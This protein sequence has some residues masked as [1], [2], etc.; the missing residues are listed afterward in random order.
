MTNRKRRGSTGRRT[1][2]RA[3]SGSAAAWDP[4]RYA[5]RLAPLLLACWVPGAVVADTEPEPGAE[6]PGSLTF[7]G[8]NLF[9]RANGSF[10]RWRITRFDVDWDRI[11]RGVVEVEVDVASIDTGIGRRD[12]HLR[13]ADFFEVERWPKARVR[14]HGARLLGQ[15]DAGNA[16]YAA[17]FDIRIRDVEKTLEG[18]FEILPGSPKTLEGELSLNRVDFGVGG[19]HA[20]WNPMSVRE[21]IPIRFSVPLPQSS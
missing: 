21:E 7:L 13:S 8:R 2:V 19:P 14:V 10:E 3:R 11:E 4:I 15:S 5:A 18:E 17:S 1:G 16:R 20:G 9:A 6:A 12:E